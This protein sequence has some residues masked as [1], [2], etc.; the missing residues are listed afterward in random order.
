MSNISPKKYCFT[1]PN[2]FF[3]F[4]NR[5]PKNFLKVIFKFLIEE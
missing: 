1:K 4:A 5:K 3:F 2:N